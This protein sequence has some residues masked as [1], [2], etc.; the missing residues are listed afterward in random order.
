MYA[1]TTYALRKK[2]EAIREERKK[3]ELLNSIKTLLINVLEQN[4]PIITL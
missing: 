2:K 1:M 4:T 3:T